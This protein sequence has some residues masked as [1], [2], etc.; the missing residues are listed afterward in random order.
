VARSIAQLRQPTLV[1]PGNN[2][3]VDIE[4]LAAELALQ[5]GVSRI[6]AITR[7][8]ASTASDIRL[9]GYSLHELRSQAYDVDIIA[10]R[11]HSMGGPHL[12]FPDYMAATYAIDSL[13][14]SAQRMCALVDAAQAPNLIFV[15]HN[16]PTGLGVHPDA[17][18]GCDFKPDG[19][20][21]GDPDLEQ[22]IDYAR[23]CGKQVLAVVAGHM[24]LHTKQGSE[25]P[26]T[27]EQNGTLYINSARVPR[28]FSSAEGTCRHHLAMTISAA[29]IAVT[30][31]L[32]P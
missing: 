17:I 20:D 3:T 5:G 23:A 24:H 28:I 6:L 8:T 21:W 32:Q 7:D 13:E 9:C 25:R 15:A 22:V 26:W 18:W 27:V 16:G 2:D 14:N 31:V 10:G 4:Q 29:G 12:S 19:G 11:P 30:E 1:M